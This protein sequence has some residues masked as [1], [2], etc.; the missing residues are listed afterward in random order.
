M[1]DYDLSLGTVHNL[2]QKA[3]APARALNARENLGPV[4]IGA[5][6][7]IVQNGRPVLVG[8][9]TRSTSCYLLRLEDH[10]DADTWAVRVLE[11]R[12]RGLAPTA[13]VA[14]AGR[15]LRAGRTAALPAVPCRSDVFHALQDVHAVVSL[16]EHR[17]DRAMA[18]ADR[19]RQKVAG[20]VRRNQPV[21]P[22]VSH[23]L[24]QA[25]RED[26]RAIEQADQVALLAH[27]LRHDVLG[28]AGPPHPERV[29]RY[30]VLRAERDARTAAAPTHL[31]QRVRYLRGQRDDLLAFAAE[32]AAAFVALAEPLELDPQIIR[33]L[34]GVRTLAVQDRRRWPR[35]AALRGGLGTHYDPLAQAVEALGQRTVRASSL[36]ENRNSRLRGYFFLRCHLGHDDLALLQFFLNHR[37]FPRSEHHE[38][39]DKSPIEVLC[40]EAQP[41]WLESL[42]F[43]RF[44]RT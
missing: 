32:R 14:D 13:I 1:L 27:G 41:H 9:D 12:D 34:F 5:H 8:V 25:D 39:V 36:A 22:R 18:A 6:D 24:S 15:G 33:E 40:G 2:V 11:L 7:E 43:T 42:G 37:R 29:A 21:D 23:R 38:R 17:A 30:D 20:R 4:R 10:R 28:L 31:G 3:V 16:L 19:L 44:V 35:D 26:A